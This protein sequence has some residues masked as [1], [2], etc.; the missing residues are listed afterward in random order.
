MS[1]KRLIFAGVLLDEMMCTYALRP[2]MP[3][4]HDE[5]ETVILRMASHIAKA[6]RVVLERVHLLNR[7]TAL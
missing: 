1:N 7:I 6:N 3:K 4:S 2:S 5:K